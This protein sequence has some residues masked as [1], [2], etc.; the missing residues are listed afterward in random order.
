MVVKTF[1]KSVGGSITA[2]VGIENRYPSGYY[3]I[4]GLWYWSDKTQNWESVWSDWVWVDGYTSAWL[5]SV[6]LKIRSDETKGWKWLGISVWRWDETKAQAVM[7][8]VIAGYWVL[9]T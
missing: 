7:E 3:F 8:D 9:V 4:F 1:M 5:G 6:T 2:R